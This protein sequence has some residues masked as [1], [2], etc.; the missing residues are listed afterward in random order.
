[1]LLARENFGCGS[2]R[3]HAPWALEQY[4]FR[5]LI[6]PSYADIFFN[7]CFKNG[8]LPIVLPEAQVARLFDE[9]A[10]FPGYR[11]TVDLPRQV[12]VKPDGERAAVRRAAVS[13]VLPGQRLRRHRP[14]AAPC[15]QDPRLRGRA[16]GAHAV[17]RAASV[18]LTQ[19]VRALRR[20][21]RRRWLC[22]VVLGLSFF[23]FGAG[24]VNLFRLLEANARPDCS[25][26]A[27][28]PLVDGAAQQL[29][30]LVA[31]RLP[32]HDGLGD[33][34]GL[35]AP[36]WCIGLDEPEPGASSEPRRDDMK[37]RCSPAR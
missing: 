34:Q 22:F 5:A 13:Q 12:V 16:P 9:V 32:Q 23:A 20:A 18:T 30:E 33:L 21:R 26:M 31:T 8:V 36:R 29:A 35:R 14:D 7:N 17:A 6:A 25:S 10:A 27:G 28:R 3:E 37:I 19:L 24:T 2:S 4:G 15:R 1:M 11:L